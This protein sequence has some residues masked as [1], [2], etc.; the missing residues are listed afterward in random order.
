MKL[1]LGSGG[2]YPYACA[3]V[4][5]K[6]AALLTKDNYPKLLLMDLNEIGRFLGETQ[7]NV[8]M[9]ELAS[10]YDGVDLI[11]LG[12]SK[13]LARVYND[14]L[15]FTKGELREMVSSYLARWDVWNIKTI[16]RGKF[17]G[18]K[19]EDIRE[20]LVPAGMLREEAL[21][22]L[23]ALESV[24]EVLEA[25]K[26]LEGIE[27]P[28]E[29]MAE[30]QTSGRLSAVEDY[31]DK[32]YYVRLLEAID[33]RSR[34]GQLLLAFIRKEID[35]TNLI[36]LLKLKREKVPPERIGT[37]L[38]EG[39]DELTLRELERLAATESFEALVAELNTYSFYEDIKEA[40]EKAKESG[41]LND[42]SLAAKKHLMSRAERFSRLYP[43]S[44]LPII[45]FMIRKKTEVDN[46]RIVARCKES[47]LDPE[48]TK[49]LL[50]T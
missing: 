7:Y 34:P 43:L 50:V 2:N 20:D 18:A 28:E 30:Y 44:V 26:K 46:I 5:A 25:V 17:Y 33:T 37:Y 1:S 12:T 19:I 42:V 21:D 6:K 38:I 3:R 41:S 8:E 10:R 49:R 35:M 48:T 15:G 32:I 36:T 27:I 16:L 47:G 45:D 14:I 11:E 23:I 9:T 24:A 40:L 22:A 4:R 29:V 13:N 39:G 31:L